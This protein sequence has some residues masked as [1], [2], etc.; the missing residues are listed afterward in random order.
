MLLFILTMILTITNDLSEVEIVV[1]FILAFL[2]SFLHL[3]VG[4]ILNL[5]GTL[6]QDWST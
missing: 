6:S 2:L 4:C 5:D 3:G 1:L